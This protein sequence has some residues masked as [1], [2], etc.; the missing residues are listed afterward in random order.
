M[1]L[2]LLSW[3]I[4]QGQHLPEII[5]FLKTANADIIGLQE[6]IEKDSTNTAK[7]IARE[8][9][10][11]YVYYQAIEKTR[12]G[13]P[14]GNAILSKYPIKE[15]KCHF[16]SDLSTYVNTAE[17]EPRIAVEAEIKIDNKS[18]RVFTVHLAY[19]HKFQSSKIRDLQVDNLIKLL[20]HKETILLGDFNSHP[21]SA[22]MTQLNKLLQNTDADLTQPT[23]T[24]YPFD[25]EG[26]KETELKHRLDYIFVTKD[27]KVLDFSI[28]KSKGSD[29]LPILTTIQV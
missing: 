20:P 28:G 13:Y 16:L 4:W 19:S 27:I 15:S 25:Y 2:E 6:I 9:D 1:K 3:N 10:Y 23:W 8:L 14:Q 18:L 22:Y 29:H 21:D 11:N 5:E 12:L 26:F 17:S 24:I 7:E